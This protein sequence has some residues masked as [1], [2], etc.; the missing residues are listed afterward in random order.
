MLDPEFL[1]VL[2][3][4]RASVLVIGVI[5]LVLFL[6]RH[7]VAALSGKTLGDFY[8]WGVVFVDVVFLFFLVGCYFFAE[9][10]VNFLVH[11]NIFSFGIVPGGGG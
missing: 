5:F 3:T 1:P 7:L 6:I 2:L 11:S 4:F 8:A 9:P 10:F